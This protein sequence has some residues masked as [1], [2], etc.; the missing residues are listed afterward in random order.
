MKH[1][2]REIRLSIIIPFYNV[3]QYIAQ[4]LDS[5]YNQDISEEEYEV[6]CVNDCSPDKSIEIVEQ[7][8]KKH[9]NLIIVR[10]AQNRKLGGAR[11][12]GMEIARGKYVWFVDSDDLIEHNSI[13]N[14]LEIA[15]ADNLDMLHFNYAC[16]P[17]INIPKHHSTDTEV[18]SGTNMFF[19]NRF[20]WYHD[21]VTAWRKLYRRQFLLD[22]HIRFAEHI[23]YEDNDYAIL[24]FAYAERVKHVIT[25]A[26]Y[27]RSNPESITRVK[28]TSTHIEYWLNLCHRLVDIKNRLIREERDPRFIPLIDDF[29]KYHI[30]NVLDKYM[31]MDVEYQKESRKIICRDIDSELKPYTPRKEYYK[32]KLHL[33]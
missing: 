6:I 28:L 17:N 32:I 9:S 11:N 30:H 25:K 19:D 33:L 1:T 8:A 10:N 3:E 18:M 27:Y 4:C 2:E 13:K 14:L 26:Y 29:I 22:N 23:M 24:V 15:D 5:V 16:F 7:Y 31:N 12:A 21:L 20:I